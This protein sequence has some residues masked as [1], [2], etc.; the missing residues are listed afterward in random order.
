[1]DVNSEDI[2]SVEVFVENRPDKGSDI[3]PFMAIPDD[4]TSVLALFQ[5]GSVD[6]LPPKWQSMGW[7]KLRMRSGEHHDIGLFWTGEPTGAYR[8]DDTYYRGSTDK[9]LV[10]VLAEMNLHTKG[11]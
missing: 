3:G 1:M 9:K 4:Y 11:K 7:I 5:G 6:R 8:I 2:I 10:N